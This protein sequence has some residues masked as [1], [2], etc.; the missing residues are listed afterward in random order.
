[1]RVL[2]RMCQ[3][4]LK[5]IAEAQAA[6]RPAPPPK[7]AGRIAYVADLPTPE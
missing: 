1:M 7:C 3:M 4:L 2:S 6:T 5:G